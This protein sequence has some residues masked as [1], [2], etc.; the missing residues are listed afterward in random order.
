[1]NEIKIEE[2]IKGEIERDIDNLNDNKETELINN[3][4]EDSSLVEERIEAIISEIE[5]ENEIEYS[6]DIT[7]LIDYYIDRLTLYID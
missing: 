3:L 4:Y 6:G 7:E 1:M 2:L 5:E